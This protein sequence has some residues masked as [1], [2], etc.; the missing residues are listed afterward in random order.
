MAAVARPS[1]RRPGDSGTREAI[2]RAAARQFAEL[3]Y[4]RTSLRRIAAEAGVDPAL[5]THFFGSKQQL[6]VTVAELPFDP[7]A[8]LPHLL[9]DETGA[10]ERLARFLVGVLES[11]QGRRRMTGLVRAAASEPTA[12]AMVRE[13]VETKLIGALAKELGADQ[14]A[15]RASLAGSQVVGL[16]TA[17]YIVGVEPLASTDPETV[18]A[19]IAPV[20]QHY[21]TEPLE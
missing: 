20:L 12:A 2:Q 19:A 17:R 3:G 14:P 8:A 18:I 7:A 15:L 10:G 1:G 11:E 13:L 9:T 6:F 21:L 5:V 4:D 16:V